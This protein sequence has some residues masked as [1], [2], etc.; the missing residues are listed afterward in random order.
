MSKMVPLELNFKMCVL[1]GL[2]NMSTDFK[3]TIYGYFSNSLIT[4]TVLYL[5]VISGAYCIKNI[6]DVG[7]VTYAFYVIAA[8]LLGL[9]WNVVVLMQ[10]NTFKHLLLDLRKIVTESKYM[11]NLVKFFNVCN[12][13]NFSRN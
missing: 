6:S 4:L 7:K 5:V 8:G 9:A 10:R 3:S 12:D 1:I 13:T 2:F 11:K